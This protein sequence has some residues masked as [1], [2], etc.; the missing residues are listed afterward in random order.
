M[1]TNKESHKHRTYDARARM[2]LRSQLAWFW[3]YPVVTSVTNGSNISWQVLYYP[4]PWD[5]SEILIDGLEVS[6]MLRAKN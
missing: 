4:E 6:R 2:F 1:P 3:G 5:A